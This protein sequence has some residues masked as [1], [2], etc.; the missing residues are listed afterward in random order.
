MMNSEKWINTL[1]NRNEIYEREKNQLNPNIWTDTLPKKKNDNSFRKYS[2]V[3]V[4]FV[5]GFISVSVIKNETRDLQKEIDNLYTSIN[6][7]K[8]NLHKATLDHEVI[9]SPENISR[10]ANE[11]LELELNPYNK[12]QIKEL[13]VEKKVSIKL[14]KNI[15]KI[16]EKLSDKMKL[17]VAKKISKKKNELKKLQE[18]YNE[19]EKLPD[20]I[21][22]Q[23]SK[24]ITKTKSDLRKLYSD[25]I[26]SIDSVKAQRWAVVQVVKAFLGIPIIPGK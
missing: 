5:I 4:I 17:I 16:N 18:M 8:L 22:S 12:S 21:K 2:L 14:G 25:P 26:G 13:N 15:N 7:L 9:A 3:T 23:V 6:S 24:K 19:P 1:P 20:E 11:Y 10:L